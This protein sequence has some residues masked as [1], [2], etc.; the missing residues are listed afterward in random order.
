MLAVPSPRTVH[1][2]PVR[3]VRTFSELAETFRLLCAE[4]NSN[5]DSCCFLGKP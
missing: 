1:T 5:W 3:S 2:V 4:G